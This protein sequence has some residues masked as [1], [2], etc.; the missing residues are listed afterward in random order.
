MHSVEFESDRKVRDVT[1]IVY[2]LQFA[3]LIAGVTALIGVIINYLKR[4][5][6]AGTLYESHFTWQIRTF[7]GA[8]IGAVVGGVTWWFFLG[9]LVWAATYVWFIYRVVRGFLNFNDGKPM[10]L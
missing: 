7:W 2:I 5:E 10:P 9:F 8:V 6:A 3:S 4:D 1:L